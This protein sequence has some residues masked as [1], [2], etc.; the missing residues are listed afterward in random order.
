MCSIYS[1]RI[2]EESPDCELLW[3][4]RDLA[5]FWYV[6]IKC[7]QTN[8]SLISVCCPYHVNFGRH[9]AYQQPRKHQNLPKNNII[10]VNTDSQRMQQNILTLKQT[11]KYL[12]LSERSIYN[13]IKQGEL[14]ATKILNKWRFDKRE[15]DKIFKKT[16]KF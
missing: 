8:Y 6:L 1:T 3:L 10:R 12:Q 11:A 16:A 5:T 7:I 14:P 4:L 15:I 9:I 2:F 13:L